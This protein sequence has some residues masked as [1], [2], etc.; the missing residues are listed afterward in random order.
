VARED[1]PIVIRGSRDDVVYPPKERKNQAEIA[2]LTSE[3]LSSQGQ[4]D[5]PR[6]VAPEYV[7]TVSDVRIQLETNRSKIAECEA[8]RKKLFEDERYAAFPNRPGMP[9]PDTVAAI[10]KQ[11]GDLKAERA[12]LETALATLLDRDDLDRKH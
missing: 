3:A 1:D 9:D 12:T 11:L 10:D 6:R 5:R 4:V 2:A 7:R 8:A